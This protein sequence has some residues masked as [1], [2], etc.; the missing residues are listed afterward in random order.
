MC[1]LVIDI[2]PLLLPNVRLIFDPIHCNSR[3]L[4]CTVVLFSLLHH[5]F[6]GDPS[7]SVTHEFCAFRYHSLFVCF[8]SL[9]PFR[10]HF[11]LITFCLSP[12][13]FHHHS[14]HLYPVCMFPCATVSV[15]RDSPVSTIVGSC[16]MKVVSVA[17]VLWLF[18][19][20]VNNPR[21]VWI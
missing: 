2:S 14:P 12:V 21:L 18:A 1:Q 6:G 17:L 15:K 5:T 4:L 10:S 13:S 20:R 3:L 9:F 7:N 11:Q 19:E 8:H 16:C